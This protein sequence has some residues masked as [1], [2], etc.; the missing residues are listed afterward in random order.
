MHRWPG[1]IM[2]GLLFLVPGIVSILALSI[3]Y[4]EF[5]NVPAV[6]AAFV[7]LK[8]A[9]LAIVL[10]AV[11]RVGSRALKGWPILALTLAAFIGIFFLAVPFPLIV[12]G[13][14][15]IGFVAARAGS[16]AFQMGGHGGGAA[17]VNDE[18]LL[19]D[20]LPPHVQP[21]VGRALRVSAVWLVLWL[22]PILIIG[23]L[24]G[25][26]SV[27]TQIGIFFTKMAVVTFGGA[28]AVLAYMAQQTVETYGW[29]KPGEMLDGLGMAAYRV[30]A[31]TWSDRRCWLFEPM[32]L[33]LV[34]KQP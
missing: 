1:A 10:E 22:A 7:G 32:W 21:T 31:D 25:G 20:E 2:A 34:V 9:V 14:A 13:A 26:A 15:A 5:G 29:L 24:L 11:H 28:Y 18:S 17:H 3:I 19:G 4:A 16:T 8:A 30:L 33:S 27:Y 12:L 6:A 23:A